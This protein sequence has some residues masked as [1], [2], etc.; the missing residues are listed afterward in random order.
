[1]LAQE[2]IRAKRDGARLSQDEIA[3]FV[4]GITDQ[5]ISEGQVAAFAMAVFFRGMD[6]KETRRSHPRDDALGRHAAMGSRPAPWSTSTRPAA[7]ATM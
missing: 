6:R 5:S 7:S 3:F 2:V 4:R 1:M